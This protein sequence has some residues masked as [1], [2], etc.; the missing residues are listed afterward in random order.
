MSFR[1]MQRMLLCVTCR[2]QFADTSRECGIDSIES[3]FDQLDLMI[4]EALYRTIRFDPVQ[5]PCSA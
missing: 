2:P 4:R 5:N 3:G 1:R